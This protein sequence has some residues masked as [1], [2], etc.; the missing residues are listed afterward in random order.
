MFFGVPVLV[1]VTV[2]LSLLL[3]PSPGANV[4]LAVTDAEQSCVEKYWS[5]VH[6]PVRKTPPFVI[7]GGSF[8]AGAV[9]PNEL[10]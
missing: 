10:M 2:T 6:V 7:A 9:L 8:V 3:G 5:D 1:S 4:T